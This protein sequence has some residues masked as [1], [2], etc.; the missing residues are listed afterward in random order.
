M[1]ETKNSQKQLLNLIKKQGQLTLKEAVTQTRLSKTTIREHFTILEKDGYI[2]RFSKREGRGRP[3]LVYK[4]TP[5]GHRLFPS[6]DTSFLRDLLRYLKK[7]NQQEM[8]GGFFEQFWN[9]RFE[10]MNFRLNQAEDDSVETKVHILKDLLEEQGFMPNI[11]IDDNRIVV[12]ECNCPFS[13]TIKETKLPCKLEAVF[14]Q[15]ILNADLSRVNYIPDG[16]HSCSYDLNPK[17]A[18][19]IERG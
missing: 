16:N 1:L 8:I 3:E 10:E 9:K 4:L 19:D 14:I 17:K 7:M 13:E 15:K 11:Q 2:E 6:L 5:A 12:E 18:E